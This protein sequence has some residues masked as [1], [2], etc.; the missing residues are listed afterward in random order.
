M[1]WLSHP[2]EEGLPVRMAARFIYGMSAQV[3]G[4][5]LLRAIW[6]GF[7]P[8]RSRPMVLCLRAAADWNDATVRL[9]DLRTANATH[10]LVGH[11]YSVTSVAYSPDGVTL[12]SGG[13]DGTVR[14]W[15]ANTGEHQRTMEGHI[16][17]VASIAFSPDGF[18]GCERELGRHGASMEF[19]HR[20]TPSDA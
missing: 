8:S 16:G 18:N 9:W 11:Q 4:W 14:I 7:L 15:D 3:S 2:M 12:A 6:G 10:A 17:G 20:G 13:R 19:W 1:P 5:K